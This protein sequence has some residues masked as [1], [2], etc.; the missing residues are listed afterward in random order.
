MA[1]LARQQQTVNP[2]LAPLAWRRRS[3]RWSR[4][5]SRVFYLFISP[6]MTGFLGLTVLPLLY[7]LYIS[8]TDFDGVS[9]RWHW[10]GLANYIELFHDTDALFSLSRT[11][12]YTAIT[13][14][15][16][17]AGGL[18]LALLVNRRLRGVGIF[19]TL[20]YLPS[21]VPVVASA[22]MWKLIFD[23]DAGALNALLEPFGIQAI[24]WLV[25]PTVF[26]A[27]IILVLWGMGGG[28]VISLAGLQGIPAELMESARVD[29]A[30]SW[31]TFRK[32]V[33]PLLSPVLFFQVITGVIYSLQTFVQPLLLAPGNG[34]VGVASVAPSNHLFMIDV[35]E[36][37][38]Y[39][40]RFGYGSAMLWVFFVLILAIT[41][42][43]FRSSTFWVYYEVDRE[44]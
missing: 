14:P 11:V 39:N 10:V 12:L 3:R 29:G 37:F 36:Q 44:Q 43:V 19:R 9:S 25:D 35:Y 8:F 2:D 27:L 1:M 20:F 22:I 34:A 32:I 13:V 42:L 24:T 31:Q 40:Q 28:M 5:S 30:S 21:V 38:L 4:Y 18:G 6:W 16:S 41:L 33:L 23:R 26:Y 15:L 7:A 17:V